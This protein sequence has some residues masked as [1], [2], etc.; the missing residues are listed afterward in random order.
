[1][2]VSIVWKKIRC[3]LGLV[4]NFSWMPKIDGVGHQN[5][6]FEETTA[7]QGV[8]AACSD[9]IGRRG[10]ND[11][12][13][14]KRKEEARVEKGFLFW[15]FTDVAILLPTKYSVVVVIKW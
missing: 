15:G 8:E 9:P 13:R 7:N 3:L 4:V 5:G 1:M 11:A 10:K 14:P 12:P 6:R 2:G